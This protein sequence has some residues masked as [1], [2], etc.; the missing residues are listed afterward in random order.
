M[1]KWY[2]VQCF[3]LL[4]LPSAQ[5]ER[6]TREHRKEMDRLVSCKQSVNIGAR[7]SHSFGTST[8]SSVI[9][10]CARHAPLTVQLFGPPVPGVETKLEIQGQ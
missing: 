9:W 3:N 8:A 6:S 5:A 1:A 4:G 2:V 7:S 10:G